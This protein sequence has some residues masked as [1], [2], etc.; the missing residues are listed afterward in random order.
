MPG[1]CFKRWSAALAMTEILPNKTGDINVKNMY[2]EKEKPTVVTVQAVSE[3]ELV[4]SA[5]QGDRNAFSELVRVHAKG[6]LNVV[7]RMCGDMLVAEDAAQE[8]FIRAWQS[9]PSFRPGTPLRNWLY[10]IAFNAAMDMLRKEKHILSDNI[11]DLP[12]TDGQPGLETLVSQHERTAMVQKAILSLPDASRAV[13]VLREY[14]GL[15]Y[16]EISSTLDIPV[17]TVMSRLNYAR[18]LLKSKLQPQLSM[19]EV[20]HA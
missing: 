14:E 17:G 7:Y 15:S 20:E 3:T 18:N 13:L 6:V 1:D 9:L 4:V 5:Q 19:L 11:E 12:L 10:R 8:T 2:S 16:Q